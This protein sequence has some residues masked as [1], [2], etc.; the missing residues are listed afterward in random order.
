[1]AGS[2]LRI[3]GAVGLVEEPEGVGREPEDLARLPLSHAVASDRVP[4]VK[5]AGEQRRSGFPDKAGTPN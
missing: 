1:M 2:F 5:P 4:S 3:G